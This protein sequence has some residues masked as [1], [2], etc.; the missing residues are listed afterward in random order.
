MSAALVDTSGLDVLI[1]RHYP[2]GALMDHAGTHSVTTVTV[3]RSYIDLS[4][5]TVVARKILLINK[6]LH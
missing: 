1:Y 3:M 2:V 5:K 6:Q 4:Y